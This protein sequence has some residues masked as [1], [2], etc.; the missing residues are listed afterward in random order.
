[1][2]RGA[3]IFAFNNEITDYVALAAWSA[4][5]I[6][7][8]LG[9]PVAVVTDQATVS[10]FDLVINASSD[11]LN[12]RHF[13]D[14]DRAVTWHN[15]NRAS[16]YHLSP[17]D[18]TLVLD[19]DYVVASDR[20]SQL[21][22]IDQDFLA[23]RWAS[24]VT[25]CNDFNGLNW[26]GNHRMP[27]WWATVMCFRKSRTANLIFD[28]MTMI[29]D[30]W[31]HYRDLYHIPKITYRNDYALSIALNIVNGHVAYTGDIP[32][33]LVSVLPQHRLVQT[34]LDQYRLDFVDTQNRPKW[35]AI[36]GQDFHAMGKRDLEAII[37]NFS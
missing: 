9:I 23:H 37:G 13:S 25:G 4:V 12:Q 17:W 19:A 20:L 24:D 2:T 36:A 35:I 27:Q 11:Q 33:S 16:A 31:Q 34:A 18:H 30:H 28:C 22:N 14:Y 10:G 8:H 7:R 3:L 1:M 6:R 26:F 15:T 21:F 5:N 29:R 32:W